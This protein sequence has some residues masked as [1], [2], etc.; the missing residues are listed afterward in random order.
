MPDPVET[1]AETEA[2]LFELEVS[3]AEQAAVAQERAQERFLA[4]QAK[5]GER[6]DF[7]TGHS[8]C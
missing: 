2:R 3:K 5:V 1:A 6:V 4:A 7:R 8:T